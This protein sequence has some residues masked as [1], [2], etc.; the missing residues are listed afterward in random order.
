MTVVDPH[1]QFV[2]NS[3]LSGRCCCAAVA[4]MRRGGPRL[5]AEAQ[6]ARRRQLIEWRR[7]GRSSS[8]HWTKDQLP[9]TAT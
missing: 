5:E 6:I 3:F 2:D 4:L 8:R 1:V 7:T 9:V